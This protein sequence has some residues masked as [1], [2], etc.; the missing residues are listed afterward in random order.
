MGRRKPKKK[1]LG[2][3]QLKNYLLK[4]FLKNPKK[5]MNASQL[6]KKLKLKV[7]KDAINHALSKLLSKNVLR[8]VS[9]HKFVLDKNYISKERKVKEPSKNLIGRVAMIK[10]GA[11]YIIVPNNEE[12]I[13]VPAKFL[14]TALNGDE[15]EIS[16]SKYKGRKPEGKVVSV[17]KRN[18]TQI[19]GK[20]LTFRKYGI[21]TSS[22]RK[23]PFDVF[24]NPK[25]FNGAKK[26]DRV[27][28]DITDWGS[29]KDQMIWGKVKKI[30]NDLDDHN[31]TMENI[32]VENGFSSDYPDEVMEQ[33]KKIS[34]EISEEEISNRRDFRDVLTFTIDPD[35]AQDFD[36]AISYEELEN[37]NLEIGVHIADV[38]HY[39]K[40]NTPLDKEAF[41]RSTSVYL[42]DRCIAMLPEKLSN[43]LCSLVPNKDRLVFSAVFEFNKK[44]KMVR[45]WFG[46]SIIHSDKR[47]TYDEG[48][49]SL[50]NKNGL[51]HRELT[52]INKVA[53]S[54]RKEKFKNGAIAFESDEIKFILD[55][56]NRPTGVFVKQR[57]DVH[58]LIEDFM[59][60]ANKRV[61]KFVATKNKENPIP[62]V[63]RIH[64][65]PDVERLV[66]LKSL[67]E[68][69]DVTLDLSSPDK[70]AESFNTLSE[71]SKTDDKYKLLMGFAIRTMAKA[72]YS[73]DNI[74][75]YGLHF[76]HYTHFTSPIRRYSD[77]LV[78]RILAQNLKKEK[79]EDKA[80]LE[81]KCVH[82]SKQERRA[83]EAER[84]SI[85]YKQVEYM[86]DHIG[87]EYVGIVSGMIEKG[88][89]VEV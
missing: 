8:Q 29:N 58:M 28:I 34:D 84:D 31:W 80:K 17:V 63:Y 47:F 49:K 69:Y 14:G 85:K 40:A 50:D 70:I 9:D 53:H 75:H 2:T 77:V 39:M 38:T 5:R 24:V 25:D 64:D 18:T 19:M 42:V 11:A 57:K 55:E 52:A 43:N 37:G 83:M 32:L 21:V 30:M 35:T 67:M 1:K 79:R 48:Q 78:H 71:K 23:N 61:A 45:E 12:D 72:V 10:S 62:N 54:L 46:R 20:I 27:L 65:V 81:A 56:D 59:L 44:H 41:A 68:E 76:E 13:Y 33:V 6:S 87:E 86:S 82:I 60:L 36:D 16:I 15:V 26:G 74:G 3:D 7:S 22:S 88:I 51:F 66:E 89:F 4:Y 73:T